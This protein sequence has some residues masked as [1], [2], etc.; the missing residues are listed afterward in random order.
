MLGPK[1]RATIGLLLYFFVS[2]LDFL[3][4]HRF[5]TGNTMLGVGQLLTF[6]GCGFGL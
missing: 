2:S 4:V 1:E 3:G 6:G 5:Y